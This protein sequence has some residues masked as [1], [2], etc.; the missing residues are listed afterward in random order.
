MK[1]TFYHVKI[2]SYL[3]FLKSSKTQESSDFYTSHDQAW[4]NPQPSQQKCT[5]F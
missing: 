1:S 3:R 2:H 4:Y 5:S